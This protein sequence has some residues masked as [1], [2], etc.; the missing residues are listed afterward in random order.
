MMLQRCKP[1]LHKTLNNQTLTAVAYFD[2]RSQAIK[3]TLSYDKVA[4]L[5][6]LEAHCKADSVLFGVNAYDFYIYNI[7][8]LENL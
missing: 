3:A 7:A 4:Y 5:L 1:T 8:N 2:S 6:C